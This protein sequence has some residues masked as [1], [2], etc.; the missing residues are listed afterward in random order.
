MYV[1][2]PSV[3]SQALIHLL[4]SHQ[5]FVDFHVP[6]IE[7]K[8]DGQGPCPHRVGLLVGETNST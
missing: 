8:R 4:F 2:M 1:G 3:N 5:M 6:G 7:Q